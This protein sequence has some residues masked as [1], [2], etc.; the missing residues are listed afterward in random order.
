MNGPFVSVLKC[1][2]IVLAAHMY[3]RPQE[4][5]HNNVHA[6]TKLACEEAF[7]LFASSAATSI[8]SWS[9]SI[10]TVEAVKS[11]ISFRS[12]EEWLGD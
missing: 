9:G 5:M 3:I 8:R 6:W 4:H 1:Q 7:S 12:T 10:L 11:K 2:D